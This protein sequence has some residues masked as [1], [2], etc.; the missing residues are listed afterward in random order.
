M[1]RKENCRD[2]APNE[3]WFNSFKNE[4]VHGL[5]YETKEEMET[6]SLE[7][8]EVFYNR[9]RLHSTLGYKSPMQFLADWLN[10]Q[11]DEKLVA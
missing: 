7:S 3:N 2:N 11:P 1:S 5:C 4:R 6:M 10:A 9:K 8:T